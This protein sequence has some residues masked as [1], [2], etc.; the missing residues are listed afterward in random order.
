M[1]QID[2]GSHEDLQKNPSKEEVGKVGGVAQQEGL[3]SLNW[4]V[5]VGMLGGGQLAQLV[6]GHFSGGGMKGYV[7]L[8]HSFSLFNPSFLSSLMTVIK[9]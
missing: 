5:V 1:G 9:R 4:N 8:F 7:L 6:R 3:G 2:S